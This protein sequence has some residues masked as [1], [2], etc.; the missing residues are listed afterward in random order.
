[1]KNVFIK[2]FMAF[3]TFL[4]HISG[5]RVGSQ[6][7]G[8]TVLILHTIGRKSGQPRAIPIS[9]FRDGENFFVIGSNWGQKKHAGW[10]F[11]LK[12]EPQASLELAG[13]KIPVLARDA[14]GDEYARLWKAAVARYPGY[15]DY[16]K[17]AAR[18]IPIVVFEPVR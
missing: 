9:Y 3:N 7:A 12:S 6:L 10:Y 2:L 14:E 5:G 11:N 1:M 18:H 8:Q 13:K 4:I 16:Q 15:E 17:T